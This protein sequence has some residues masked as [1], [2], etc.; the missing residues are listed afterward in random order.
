MA[1]YAAVGLGWITQAAVL[2]AFENARRNSELVALVSGD[3]RKRRELGSR[4]GIDEER[5]FHYDDYG[6]CL[7]DERVDAVYIGL[8]NHLHRE[9]AVRA[10]EAGVHVLCEKPMAVTESECRDMIEAARQNDVRLM[11]AYRL[12]F[13]PANL[14]VVEL[15]RSGVVGEPRVFSSVFTQNVGAGDIRLA[16]PG[17]GG[18]TLY[19]IGIYC[20]N[21]ARYVFRD[22]PV[23]V[24]ATASTPSRD[25]DRFGAVPE[26][27]ACVLRFGDGRLA[28]FACSFGAAP[29]SD[30]RVIGTGGSIRLMNAY[31]FEGER[32]LEY[33]R[34]GEPS[35]I[36]FEP[37]DQFGP[38]LLHFSDCVQQHRRPAASGEEGAADVR[39]IEALRRSLE[40][41]TWVDVEPARVSHRPEPEQAI[42]CPAIEPP[43]LIDAN[44]AA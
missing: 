19:D 21:A 8:P 26:M 1:S 43:D 6:R 13:D 34:D 15:V 11:I 35:H 7:A 2:P 16:P 17:K 18:G 20:L 3:E 12:H 39:I 5:R 10:A 25:S 30:Y 22:E 29:V 14:R 38:Q 32:V 9:Y 44:P 37:M 33:V 28:Q 42:R 40:G 24:W 36:A 31:D 41:D 27:T 23:A 4:Y